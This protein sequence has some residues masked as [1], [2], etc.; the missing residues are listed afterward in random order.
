MYIYGMALHQTGETEDA[1]AFLSDGLRQQLAQ[2][3]ARATRLVIGILS[4]S[5]MASASLALLAFQLAFV[6]SLAVNRFDIGRGLIVDEANAIGTTYLRH[7]EPDSV[8][9]SMKGK[10]P[11]G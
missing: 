10:V 2:P 8:T 4:I 6:T 5:T 3:D 9:R 1:L 11:G 7:P